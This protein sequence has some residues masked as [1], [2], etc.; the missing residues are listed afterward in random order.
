MYP[1]P[2]PCPGLERCGFSCTFTDET[3]C[4]RNRT[5]STTH[6]DAPRGEGDMHLQQPRPTRSFVTCVFAQRTHCSVSCPRDPNTTQVGMEV[7]PLPRLAHARPE[8]RRR[9]G[10]RKRLREAW[11]LGSCS[12][13]E[14]EQGSK[15]CFTLISREP[16]GPHGQTSRT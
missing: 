15:F 5:P 16:P 9:W 2:G 12:G 7:T 6:P 13:Q 10:P 8:T 11:L 14:T 4:L 3:A 1:L